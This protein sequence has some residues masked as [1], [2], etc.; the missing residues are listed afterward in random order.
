MITIDYFKQNYAAELTTTHPCFYFTLC[1]FNF[2][3]MFNLSESSEK[4]IAQAGARE[5]Y[6]A[7]TVEVLEIQV[8]KGFASSSSPAE[9]G[10]GGSWQ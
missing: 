6:V 10:D 3:I 4:N 1:N 9:W 2:F 8:E 7:P 5:L